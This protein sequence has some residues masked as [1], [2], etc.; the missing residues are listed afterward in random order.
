MNTRIFFVVY[1]DRVMCSATSKLDADG[2]WS[3]SMANAVGLNFCDNINIL[4]AHSRS[5]RH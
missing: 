2:A 5:R 4:Y 3:G 1:V